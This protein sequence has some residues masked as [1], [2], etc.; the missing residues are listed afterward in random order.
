[1]NKETELGIKMYKR[2]AEGLIKEGVDVLVYEENS[3]YKYY[4]LLDK[5]VLGHIWVGN[6]D[7]DYIVDFEKGHYYDSGYGNAQA[8]WYYNGNRELLYNLEDLEDFITNITKERGIVKSKLG[9]GYDELMKSKGIE[10]LEGDFWKYA[11]E[12]KIDDS[13]DY[14]GSKKIES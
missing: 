4:M 3:G 9:K 10:D 6:R 5:G 14:W 11:K 12:Y 2:L 1:M 7:K 8:Y 13:W